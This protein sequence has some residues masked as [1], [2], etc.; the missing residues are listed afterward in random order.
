MKQWVYDC[1]IQID[2]SI[3]LEQETIN[4][5]IELRFNPGEGVAHLASAPKELFILACQACTTQETERV[6]KQEKALSAT[7]KTRQLE[8]LLCLSK[9]TTRAP[10]HDF[11]ELKINVATCNIH[12]PGVGPLWVQLRLL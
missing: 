1:H 8:D 7:K 4:A 2:T 9:G 5:I 6:H 3:Y 10:A 11:W 12:V